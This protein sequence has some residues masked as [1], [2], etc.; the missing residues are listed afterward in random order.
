[1]TSALARPAKQRKLDTLH[2]LEH[3]VDAWVATAAEDGAAPYLVPLSYVWDGAT[4]LF[5]TPATSPTGRNLLATGIARVGVGPTRD[6]V[7]I[8]GTAVAVPPAE[9]PEEDAEIFAG[10]TGFDPRELSARYLYF[11]VLPGRIQAWRE[12]DELQGREL[13]RD[14]EWLVAD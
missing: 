2:R 10:K 7:M 5:A 14:G 6:V 12:A 3:D 11:R 4:L 9:L 13:M 8:E 1:M